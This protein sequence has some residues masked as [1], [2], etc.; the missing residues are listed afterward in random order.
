MVGKYLA[1]S[2]QVRGTRCVC[3]GGGVLDLTDTVCDRHSS[4]CLKQHETYK[5]LRLCKSIWFLALR[6]TF[7]NAFPCM[8]AFPY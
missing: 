2:K 6:S 5:N 1:L 3:G 8:S 4:E 7:L